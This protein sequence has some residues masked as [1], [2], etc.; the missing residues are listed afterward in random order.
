MKCLLEGSAIV[1]LCVACPGRLLRLLLNAPLDEAGIFV[2][3][4]LGMALIA[5]GLG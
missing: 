2:A 4:L 1:E 5:M 3:R